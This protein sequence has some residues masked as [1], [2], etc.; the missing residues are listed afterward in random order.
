MRSHPHDIFYFA[1]GDA[2]YSDEPRVLKTWVRRVHG[3]HLLEMASPFEFNGIVLAF[4][5]LF[6]LPIPRNGYD[7]Y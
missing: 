7:G 3:A 1:N 6:L 4:I 2:V 5:S